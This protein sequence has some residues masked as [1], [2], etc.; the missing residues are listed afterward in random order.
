MTPH[1]RYERDSDF[2]LRVYERMKR[3][4]KDVLYLAHANILDISVLSG[5]D[6]S[7]LRVLLLPYNEIK[8][9]SWLSGM[10]L[11][12]LKGLHLECNKIEDISVLSRMD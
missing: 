1:P 8:D 7:D 4:G 10:D 9:I 5:M 6:L 2:I 12:G 3:E 11:S